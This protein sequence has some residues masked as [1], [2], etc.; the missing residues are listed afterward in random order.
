MNDQFY[1]AFEERY[2]GSQATIKNLR[3]QYLEFVEPLARIYPGAPV[4]D[5]GCGRG[6]WLELM[7][8]LRFEPHGCDLD[9]GML[10]ACHEKGLQAKNEDAIST[11]CSLP[12]ESHAVITAFH[13]VE[14]ISF[15]DLRRF[16]SEA[17]RI[18]KPGGVLIL[19]TPNPENLLVA[20]RNFYLD[21]THLR[22]IPF[23]LLSFL[24]TYAGFERVKTLRL[25]E[26]KELQTKTSISI[27]DVICGVSPDYAVVCQKTAPIDL[28]A[29]LDSAFVKD[30]GLSMDA[31]TERFEARLARIEAKAEESLHLLQNTRRANQLEAAL[32]EMRSSRSWKVTAPLR[33][34]SHQAQ[35]IQTRGIRSRAKA[36]LIKVFNKLNPK[37]IAWSCAT[38]KK[39]ISLVRATGLHVIFSRN[40]INPES[41]TPRTMEIY[42]S[43]RLAIRH[44]KKRM[45]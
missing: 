42:D 11:L 27:R 45:D 1:R 6:E 39:L 25:Q 13:V 30:Y 21:P 36:L 28:L 12:S 31:L 8:D 24:A 26:D 10:A 32:G 4:F 2:Y 16:I 29:Q 5:A 22:P 44:Q 17:H 40:R 18:L 19:E 14:H 23:E 7:Q 15:D 33:W 3:K 35:L 38:K 34:A 9:D 20:T 37:Y 41:V 43:L